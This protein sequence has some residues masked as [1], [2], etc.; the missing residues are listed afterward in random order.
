MRLFLSGRI[1]DC[2]GEATTYLY[3]MCFLSQAPVATIKVRVKLWKLQLQSTKSTQE[4]FREG[5]SYNLRG[6]KR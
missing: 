5:G 6:G 3:S 4:F 1:R 2:R